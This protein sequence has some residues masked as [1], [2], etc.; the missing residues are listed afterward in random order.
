MTWNRT[1]LGWLMAALVGLLV[2][3][4]RLPVDL[5]SAPGPTDAPATSAEAALSQR[6]AALPREERESV[7]ETLSLIAAGGPFPYGK[8]G[9][10]FGN[11]E[12]RLPQQAAGYY[13]EYTVET[14]GSSDRGAR[15]IVVG[16]GGEVFYTRDHYDSFMKLN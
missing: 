8:D 6:L 1:R 4:S 2:I 7:E 14:V 15:R 3:A 16:L 5:T 12:G 11:R 9:S 13:R 10:A